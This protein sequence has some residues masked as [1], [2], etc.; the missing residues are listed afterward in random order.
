M[1]GR[2]EARVQKLPTVRIHYWLDD[3]LPTCHNRDI[4]RTDRALDYMGMCNKVLVARLKHLTES[5]GSQ[6]RKSTP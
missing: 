2:Q 1:Y 4:F 5:K 6:K 3:P